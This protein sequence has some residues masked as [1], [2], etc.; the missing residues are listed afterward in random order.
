MQKYIRTIDFSEQWKKVYKIIK[1]IGKDL[2]ESSIDHYSYSL[3]DRAL[4]I[5]DAYVAIEKTNNV[6]V[7]NILLRS[8][9]E[10]KV[11]ASKYQDNK[12]LEI[13]NTNV[14]LKV[15]IERFL[16]KIEKGE[17][18][19]S[20]ILWENLKD[21]KFDIKINSEK[22]EYKRKTIRKNFE[23][24]DLGFDYEIL[25]WLTSLFIHT[26]PLS[27]AIEHK[28]Q[29]PENKIFDIL[30]TLVRDMDLVNFQVLGTLLWITRYLFDEI[31]SEDTNDLIEKLW[32]SKRELISKKYGFEW[33]TDPNVKI[34]TMKIVN[35]DGKETLLKRQ[36]RK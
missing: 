29:Y 26:N 32:A 6:S 31:L 7:S 5:F 17:S 14:Q 24:A 35:A 4:F 20:Q 11:K 1:L 15:E 16:D 34:G 19:S 13:Q 10:I 30:S 25:Y 8:L 28:E 22:I 2:N 12:N 18:F 9:Y 27:L 23:E 3:Y 36:Q 33:H 21:K